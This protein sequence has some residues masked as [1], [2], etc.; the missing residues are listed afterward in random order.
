M[1]PSRIP[2]SWQVRP[3]RPEDEPDI[4]R[5][6]ANVFGRSL[7]DGYWKWKLRSLPVRE[8]NEWVAESDGEVVGHYAV[9]PIRYRICDQDLIVPHGCDAMTHPD[10][11]RRGILYALG[12]RANEVWGRAGAPFQIGFH[13]G[14]W[15]SVRENLGWRIQT[16]LVWWKKRF[17]PLTSL[18]GKLGIP[19]KA[20]WMRADDAIARLSGRKPAIPAISPGAGEIRLDRVECADDRFDRLWRKLAPFH[21][22]LAVRDRAWVQWRYLDMPGAQ[23]RVVIAARREEPCGF[24][25]MR[26]VTRG[27]V[28]QA[29]IA[30]LFVDP[31]D[32]AAG[33][34]LLADAL[35]AA[36]TIGAGSLAALASPDSAAVRRLAAAGFRPGRHGYDFSIVPYPAMVDVWTGADWFLTGAEGDVL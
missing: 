17:R 13:Y 33:Q 23:H 36:A 2:R 28:S 24:A 12:K 22:V 29:V 9:T 25:A 31:K 6:F 8:E 19:G 21:G 5:L 30:D 14:G 10:F 4:T 34:V 27:T 1:T 20:A 7:P 16:R 15:G 11:R 3:S 35:A 32:G 18:A 26:W